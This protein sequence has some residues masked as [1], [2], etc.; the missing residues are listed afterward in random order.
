M[1]PVFA[2]L[3]ILLVAGMP[4]LV[5][6][7]SLR[8]L[9][10]NVFAGGANWPL[11]VAQE[12]GLFAANGLAV[13]V[14][15]TPN[16]VELIRGLMNGTFDIAMTTFDNVVAY[17]E[18]QGEVTLPSSPD[19]FAFMGG[20]NSALRLIVN[21]EIKAYADLKGKTLGVDAVNTG[22]ALG[23]YKLLAVHGLVP[24]DYQLA[25]TGGTI[26]R[27]QAL[28]QGKIDGTVVN[29]PL[30]IVPEAKGYRR[31]GDFLE[32]FGAYQAISGA[33][34]RSWAASNEDRLLAYIRSFVAAVDWLYD[35]ANRPE[36]IAIY[37]KFV[38][39]TPGEIADKAW[40]VMLSGK[41]GF[42]RKAKLDLQGA[43]T[44]VRIRSEFGTP[45]KALEDAA[46][47]FDE[48]YYERALAGVVK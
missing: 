42:Q 6:A 36:A 41:E 46:K 40:L 38:P 13:K 14:T 24:G 44:V 23:M 19:L 3:A 1:K 30:E 35:P 48:S 2:L 31:L 47:Y 27:V 12:K 21:P 28:M 25:R 16:S 5:V 9:E 45:R 32:S 22:Y 34:R 4:V 33:T 7:Q 17:Q 37:Q 20:I 43:N 39:E 10:V 8:P 26:F 15:S 29:S 18:G 11:F